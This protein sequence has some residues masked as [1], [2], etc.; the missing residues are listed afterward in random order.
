MHVDRQPNFFNTKIFC[1]CTY[2]AAS[3]YIEAQNFKQHGRVLKSSLHPYEVLTTL[4]SKDF[5]NYNLHHLIYKGNHQLV[6]AD[7]LTMIVRDLKDHPSASSSF[8]LTLQM[9]TSSELSQ[10]H[11]IQNGCLCVH[12]AHVS[13]SL[14]K[15]FS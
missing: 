6:L 13:I 14:S 11:S 12:I 15:I 3:F 5:V 4:L 2:V 7:M 8:E 1:T 10:E 9:R